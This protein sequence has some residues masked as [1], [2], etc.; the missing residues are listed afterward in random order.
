MVRGDLRPEQV[1]NKDYILLH[2]E[3][4]LRFTDQAAAANA[5]KLGFGWGTGMHDMDNDAHQE[6]LFAPHYARFP[7]VK[8]TR[9]YHGTFTR[10]T[11]PGL[12]ATAYTHKLGH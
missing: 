4:S 6:L 5:A 9:L 3:G 2:N 8:L 7:G 10:H 12:F 1:L 11:T